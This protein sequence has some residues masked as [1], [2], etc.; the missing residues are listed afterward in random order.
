MFYSRNYTSSSD[1][2]YRK[3]EAFRSRLTLEHDWNSGSK[4]FITFF[5]RNNKHGQN[6]SYGIRWAPGATTAKGEINSNNFESYGV[7]AQHSQ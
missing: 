3:S 5:Q 7:I 4:S 2:T 1:F 6:P